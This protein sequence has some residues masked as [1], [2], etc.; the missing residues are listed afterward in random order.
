MASCTQISK[1][2]CSPLKLQWVAIYSVFHK[3]SQHS[4]ML[5]FKNNFLLICVERVQCFEPRLALHQG[6]RHL[7][8]QMVSIFWTQHLDRKG[9]CMCVFAHW[10][11]TIV[12][13][14]A[15]NHTLYSTG[16]GCIAL[17]FHCGADSCQSTQCLWFHQTRCSTS[18]KQLFTL[19]HK[20]YALGLF[21]T[22]AASSCT[23]QM[24]RA[25]SRTAMT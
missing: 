9:V 17:W 22:D 10:L 8:K 4:K 13:N 15:V 19:P 2:I 20:E 14:S 23:E 11:A 1:E 3:D 21:L 12:T 6:Q 25:G 5:P 7:V 16:H 18:Q 24:E